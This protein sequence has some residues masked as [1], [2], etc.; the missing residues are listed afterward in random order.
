MKAFLPAVLL[1]SVS[2]AASCGPGTLVLRSNHY[3]L[4]VPEGWQLADAQGDGLGSPTVLRVPPGRMGGAGDGVDLRVYGWMDTTAADEATAQAVARLPLANDP[5]LRAVVNADDQ[6]C[7]VS[8]QIWLLGEYRR[9][10]H[11]KGASDRLVVVTAGKAA[12]SVVAVIG[13]VPSREPLCATVIALDAAMTRLGA[14]LRSSGD[15]ARVTRPPVLLEHLQTGAPITV[16]QLDPL[17]LD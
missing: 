16:P 4:V 8:N 10:V 12:G 7:P 15:L 1:A 5:A 6:R 13:I 9:A 17:P 2:L 3:R 11:L 14:A